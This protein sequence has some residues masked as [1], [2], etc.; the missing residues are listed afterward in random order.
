MITHIKMAK[1]ES[2][3]SAVAELQSV[4]ELV[5]SNNNGEAEV[6]DSTPRCDAVN[7]TGGGNSSGGKYQLRPRSLQARRRSDSEWSLQDSLRHKPRPPPLSRYRR[8][9]ANA[10]ERYRMRQINTAFESLRGVLPSWVCSR[11]PAS[12][13][14][15]ITT[16]RLAS[17][18]I[19]SLQDI[20]DG[21][22]HQDTCS[23][24]LSSILEEAS[25][26]PK[27]PQVN[28][29]P[30]I[31]NKM[32]QPPA[33]VTQESDFVTLLCNPADPGVFQ[34]NLETFSY[35]SPMSETEAMALLL[36]ND[37]P[38]TWGDSQHPPLV[39]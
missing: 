34:D 10:R 4:K 20:L 17:A 28:Q 25:T 8:K 12:D 27:Q 21:N 35:L 5:D 22:A 7:I 14:T 16:L 9:T 37:P 36:G 38:R 3:L 2:P 23:W 26:S 33:Y 6:A 32:Q 24:V 39:S 29:Y 19:R 13:M 1:M 15:K 18:Y 31:S 11:R 30:T